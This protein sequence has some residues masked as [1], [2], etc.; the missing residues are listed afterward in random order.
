MTAAAPATASTLQPV[1]SLVSAGSLS[2]NPQAGLTLSGELTAEYRTPTGPAVP[3]IFDTGASL[4]RV[5]VIPDLTLTIPSFQILTFTFPEVNFAVP[6]VSLPLPQLGLGTL[7]DLT[8]VS[9]PLPLGAV[10]NFDYGSILFGVPLSFGDVVQNQFET[11]AAFVSA[12]GTLGGFS[13]SYLYDGTLLS[14]DLI[15]ADYMLNISNP[16]LFGAMESAAL[17]FV[18]DFLADELDG[19]LGYAYGEFLATDPCVSLL[20]L[21]GSGV[22]ATIARNA[23]RSGLNAFDPAGLGLDVRLDGMGTITADYTKW[24]SITPVPVPAALPLL[25]GGLAVFGVMGLRRRKRAA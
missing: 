18:N 1:A 11:G 13:G 10:F 3:Y 2:F 23:C 8:Y 22:A 4:D 14:P 9:P 17:G 16:G 21:T 5:T 6:A 19:M 12:A 25:A 20:N 7:Y 24:K 15:V